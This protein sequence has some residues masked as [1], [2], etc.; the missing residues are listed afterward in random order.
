MRI[1]NY[2]KRKKSDCWQVRY[3]NMKVV[4][5]MKKSKIC[6]NNYFRDYLSN[7]KSKLRVFKRKFG[8]ILGGGRT[9][10][11][12]SIFGIKYYGLIGIAAKSLKVFLS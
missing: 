5:N 8:I 6:I 10:I 9:N 3:V 11:A 4:N 7:M 1:K 2:I 12:R